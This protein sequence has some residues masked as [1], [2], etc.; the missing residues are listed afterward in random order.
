MITSWH[1]YPSIY[2]MGH[3]AISELLL[4]DV[5][6]EEKIDG[7][8][9]SFGKFDDQIKI[10]SKGVEMYIDAPEKMFTAAVDYVK[11]IK[12][13]MVDGWTYRAEYLAKPKHNVLCYDR[14]PKNNLILFDINMNEE[15]YMDHEKKAAIAKVL[16]LES[17]PV[18]FSGKIESIEHFRELLATTSCLG[19]VK[20]EGVIVKNYKRFTKSKK[21]LMGKFVSEQFREVHKVEWKSSN[22]G[23]GD[24]IQILASKYKH[25]ARWL[26]AM[27]RLRD[28]G[29]LEISPRDIP[30]LMIAVKEDVA[31]ECTDEIKDELYRWAFK[32]IERQLVGGLPEW[33]KDQ[34]LRLQFENQ[35]NETG[36]NIS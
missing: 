23:Q 11:S 10:R 34:L 12:D 36:N 33:Y 22:P 21:V 20:I 1:S 17:V 13:L 8:Q 18:F 2:N 28:N 16:D 6:V 31:K 26:K 4:D 14:I 25:P 15:E 24:I 32:N 3:S 9:F 29:E 19:S 5:L 7:S 27:Q 35:P 30:K